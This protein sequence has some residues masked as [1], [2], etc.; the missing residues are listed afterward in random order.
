MLP[1]NVLYYG[2]DLP[3]LERIPLRA[4]PLTL[5]FENGDIRHIRCGEHEILR[6]VYVAVR[7]RNWGTTE[8]RISNLEITQDE[9]EFQIGFKVT[10]HENQIDFRWGAEI[11][12]Q[13]DGTIT[14]SI[15]GQAY[16]EFWRNR[17]GFCVLHPISECTGQPCEIE[18]IDGSRVQ[19][20][21]PQFISPHQPFKDMRAIIH[22]IKQGLR[23][24]VR[25]QGDT[26]EMED[27]RNWTDA[28][29]KTY[30]TPLDLPYP[31]LLK[32]GEQVQQTVQIK[33]EGS[34]D[35]D[36]ETGEFLKKKSTFH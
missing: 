14:F 32:K 18:Q 5:F 8:G 28:S 2:R 25:M 16:S 26:F 7:D 12:G 33:L 31:V 11:C 13:A 34:W 10:C 9:Y 21:F 20:Q 30:S 15:D 23:A 36:C 24:E 6:R 19:G 1:K 17:I 29:F 22:E 4:G 3:L 35:Q 27:Q